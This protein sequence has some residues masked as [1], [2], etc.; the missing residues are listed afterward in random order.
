MQARR[1]RK[2]PRGLLWIAASPFGLLA[3]TAQRRAP[4]EQASEIPNSAPGF[5]CAS[6]AVARAAPGMGPSGSPP[7]SSVRLSIGVEPVDDV[8]ADLDQALKA[9]A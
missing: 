9:A 2:R 3:M 5:R 4:W 7:C 1:A 6:G 8:L